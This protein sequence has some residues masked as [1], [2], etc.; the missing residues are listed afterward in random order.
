MAE[1]ARDLSLWLHLPDGERW[2]F[3]FDSMS[4]DV[5]DA[6][7]IVATGGGW[8]VGSVFAPDAWGAP[9]SWADLARDLAAFVENG[10][11]RGAHPR[12]RPRLHTPRVPAL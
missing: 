2:D 5:P 7:R 12:H 1:L 9:A 11:G 6:V 3:A 8:R 10:A 4:Y